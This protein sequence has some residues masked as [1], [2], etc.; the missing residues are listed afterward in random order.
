[1]RSVAGYEGV[2]AV[3]YKM[4]VMPIETSA[5][6]QGQQPCRMFEVDRMNKPRTCPQCVKLVQWCRNCHSNH[7]AGGWA[8]CARQKT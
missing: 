2:A 7:H 6:A 1:V 8:T 5:F 3:P 4:A